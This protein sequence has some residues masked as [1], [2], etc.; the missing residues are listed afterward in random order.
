MTRNRSRLLV[1]R[2]AAASLLGVLGPA[3]PAAAQGVLA[4]GTSSGGIGT[5]NGRAGAIVALALGL[6]GM[7]LGRLAL[8][9]SSRTD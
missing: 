3:A 6:T 7:V 1:A 2:L 4:T 9:R 5:G 8:V